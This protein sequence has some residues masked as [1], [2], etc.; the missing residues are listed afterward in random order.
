MD[1]RVSI[2]PRFADAPSGRLFTNTYRHSE[3]KRG[4]NVTLFVPPFA[5]E[6]NRVRRMCHIQSMMLAARGASA[7]V[8]DFYGTGDSEGDF[9]DADWK[10]W[11]SDL[12]FMMQWAAFQ[13]DVR[14]NLV[15][16][17]TGALLL[18][19]SL[20]VAPEQNID[21]IVLWQPCVSGSTYFRQF[22]RLQIAARIA[23]HDKSSLSTEEMLAMLDDDQPVEVS[24]YTVSPQLANGLIQSRIVD[25]HAD[26][27]RVHW[28]EIVLTEESRVAVASRKVISELRD[29][30]ARI[31]TRR[32]VGDQFW[33]TVEPTTSMELAQYTA[34][35]ILAHRS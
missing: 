31:E 10:T 8:F 13:E 19:D 2:E 32:V 35:A 11:S 16:I 21:T 29:R 6:A 22:L 4:H 3:K 24:G 30:G 17:R 1:S 27:L 28:Y 23:E 9:G 12:A 5:E 7:I 25:L 14:L 15:A 20:S 34:E 33:N 26:E 18:T